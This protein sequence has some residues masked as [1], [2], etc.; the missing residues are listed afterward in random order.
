VGDDAG[1]SRLR[2]AARRVV[3]GGVLAAQLALVARGYTSDHKEFA[4]QMFP[5]ASTW[6][7]D[8][9]RVD[10]AGDRHPIDGP[11]AGYRWGDLV[12]DRGLRDPGVEHH[13]DAGIDNQLASL[14][15]ALDWVAD[16]TPADT[17]TRRLEADVTYRRNDGP[18]VHVVLRSADRPVPG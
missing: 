12:T 18:P 10:A 17:A 15:S 14:R 7:A 3:V 9:Y 2:R 1:D 6:R 4:F 13:A 11:W 5:E 8:L 16:H